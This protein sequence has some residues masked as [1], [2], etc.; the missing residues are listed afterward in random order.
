[1]INKRNLWF[2]LFLK[3]GQAMKKMTIKTIKGNEL[4][5]IIDPYIIFIN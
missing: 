2:C 3:K 1:M 4:N 5:D